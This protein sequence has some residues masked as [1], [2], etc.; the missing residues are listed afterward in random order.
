[1]RG[2]RLGGGSEAL[3]PGLDNFRTCFC[4]GF[5]NFRS[6]FGPEPGFR[7][8]RCGPGFSNFSAFGNSRQK[9]D[10]SPYFGT[11]D[12]EF[13]PDLLIN[14]LHRGFV[15]FRQ[16]FGPDF[17]NF[18]QGFGNFRGSGIYPAGPGLGYGIQRPVP[19]IF[20]FCPGSRSLRLGFGSLRIG[21]FRPG[22]RL[23]QRY[24][25][26]VEHEKVGIPGQRRGPGARLGCTGPIWWPLCR[27]PRCSY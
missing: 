24:K 8:I 21:S 27:P 5:G 22:R 9:P 20:N 2:I 12:P 19:G 18:R 6:G 3:Q 26:L 7:N 17:Y 10:F 4:L 15:N 11:F 25:R 13:G 16:G 14:S 23:Q 1:M